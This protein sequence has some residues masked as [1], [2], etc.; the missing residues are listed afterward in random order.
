M[1]VQELI[2]K[3]ETLP[4]QNRIYIM[5]DRCRFR[6]LKAARRVTAFEDGQGPDLNQSASSYKTVEIVELDY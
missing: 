2:K 3:L 4:L 6:E 1:T 5:D